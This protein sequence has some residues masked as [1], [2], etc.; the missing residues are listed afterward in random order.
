LLEV[1]ENTRKAIGTASANHGQRKRKKREERPNE[2]AIEN[3]QQ[4]LS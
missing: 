4:M 3:S 2:N 1:I